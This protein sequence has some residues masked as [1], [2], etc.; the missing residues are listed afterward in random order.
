MLDKHITN[1]GY[2]NITPLIA[3]ENT[4]YG[5]GQL[6]KFEMI[7]LKLNLIKIQIENF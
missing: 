5:T 7:N 4:M 6:P 1:N 2:K 3:S